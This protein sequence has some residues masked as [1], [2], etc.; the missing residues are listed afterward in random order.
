[1]FPRKAVNK[2][3][4]FKRQG[5]KM[6]VKILRRVQRQ[7]MTQQLEKQKIL[8]GWNK[9]DS[10]FWSH[11]G[12]L[13][14]KERHSCLNLSN[15][16]RFSTQVGFFRCCLKEAPPVTLRTHGNG[17]FKRKPLWF[18]GTLFSFWLHHMAH[19]ILVP[20]QGSNSQPLCWK[21][22]VLPTGPLGRFSG[23]LSPVF[24]N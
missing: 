8:L 20:D 10:L 22:G 15:S 9:P 5:L 7:N 14:I 3:S 6:H 19:G 13:E 11:P 18:G 12:L 1:M 21:R 2:N 17:H 4:P 24:S 23:A 16:S